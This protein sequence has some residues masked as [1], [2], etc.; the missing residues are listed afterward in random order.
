M[1][2]VAAPTKSKSKKI[3]NSNEWVSTDLREDKVRFRYSV[4]SAGSA[5]SA[6][7]KG[8]PSFGDLVEREKS[9]T[10]EL[11]NEA[12]QKAEAVRKGQSEGCFGSLLR[13]LKLNVGR[14]D[15]STV[16]DEIIV[17]AFDEDF[18]RLG[19]RDYDVRDY[20]H[21]D[22]HWAVRISTS[23][24]FNR[25]IV[26]V[27]C[28]NA[29]T[30]YAL[31]DRTGEVRPWLQMA[32]SFFLFFYSFELTV[33]F[34][35]FARASWCL[36]DFWFKYD[37]VLVLMMWAE[38]GATRLGLLSEIET[39]PGVGE[40]VRPCLS[41]Y[42]MARFVRVLRAMPSVVTIGLGIFAAVRSVM[43]T[44]YILGFELFCVAVVFRARFG[45]PPYDG[46]AET[47]EEFFERTQNEGLIYKFRT[48]NEAFFACTFAGVFTDNITVVMGELS[49][50]SIPMMMMFFVHVMLTNLTLLNILVGVVCAVIQEATDAQKD[51]AQMKRMK[52]IML[53]NLENVDENNN[54]MLGPSE[55]A[56][57]IE[58]PEV[59]DFLDDE[60][61]IS[62]K[63]ME[64]MAET[65]FFDSKN[66]GHYKELSFTAF[67]QTI[68]SLR[69]GK[70]STALDILA[71]QHDIKQA[72]A[73]MKSFREELNEKM[74]DLTL[75]VKDF[76]GGGAFIGNKESSPKSSPK[77]FEHYS[78][79]RARSWTPR[80]RRT[81]PDDAIPQRRSNQVPRVH[82]GF[83]RL[84]DA[85]ASVRSPKVSNRQPS[86]AAAA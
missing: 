23:D 69:A 73:D 53:K 44:F 72:D 2:R 86:T 42:R 6:G 31:M 14:I 35:S 24:V 18:E 21:E 65:M 46:P 29:F 17:S 50:K 41:A 78:M 58:I 22:G 64:L 63:E 67:L 43:S 60:C 66:P 68:L 83:Q 1:T 20:Y 3:G 81:Q 57:L 8:K 39:L 5:G 25:A 32:E 12:P 7:D 51:S 38:F 40:V 59:A 82:D 47:E 75:L 19:E 85:P 56:K 16:D 45:G 62:P 70:P 10:L 49:R 27:I 28:A 11:K 79:V 34:F 13:F 37:L 52:E 80:G 33:R 30:I 48:V 55:F 77:S 36:K 15:S 4:G 84:D 61:S 76:T 71:L 74:D 54:N 26:S 9:R